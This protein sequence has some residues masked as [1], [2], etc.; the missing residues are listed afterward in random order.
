MSL[1]V[2]FFIN[3]SLITLVNNGD[4]LTKKNYDCLQNLKNKCPII[5][6]NIRIEIEK[7]KIKLPDPLVFFIDNE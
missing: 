3:D 4:K 1:H 6:S 2:I 7:N 5:I